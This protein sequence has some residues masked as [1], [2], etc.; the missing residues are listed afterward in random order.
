MS[1]IGIDFGDKRIGIAKSEG[2]LATLVCTVTVAGM[3]D[4]VRKTAD[5]I[6]EHN[7]ATVVIGMPKNMDSTEGYRAERTRQFAAALEQAT[8]ITPVFYDERL[9]TS[10]AYIYMNE[11]D[12]KSKKRKGVIDALSAKII[13]QDYL[14]SQKAL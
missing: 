1:Y 7:A 13:L 9:T 11:T 14:D 12:F 5:I 3:N 8:G 2:V 4:A 10:Q 6:K